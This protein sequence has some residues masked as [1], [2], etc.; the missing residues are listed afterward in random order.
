MELQKLVGDLGRHCVFIK[1]A[2]LR[3]IKAR[4]I[5]LSA[6]SKQLGTYCTRTD[7]NK[8]DIRNNTVRVVSM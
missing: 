8:P 7:K 1:L 2:R 4:G 3:T 5:C 6:A